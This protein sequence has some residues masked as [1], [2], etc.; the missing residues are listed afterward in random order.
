MERVR[1][2][3]QNNQCDEVENITCSFGMVALRKNENAESLLQRADKLLY[4]AKDSGKNVIVCE[5][6][7]IGEQIIL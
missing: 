1:I 7:R 3:I 2:C 5:V 4:D 6:G